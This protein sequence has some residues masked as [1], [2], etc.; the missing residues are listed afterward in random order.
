M[1][2]LAVGVV[3]DDVEEGHRPQPVVQ[4]G[5]LLVDGEV[6]LTVIG[7]DEPLHRPFAQ[8]SVAQHGRRD[9]TE[10]ERF[11]QQVGG[12]LPAVQ[13][14]LEVP[15]RT[16]SAHRLVDRRVRQTFVFDVDEERGVAAVRHPPLDAD[17]AAEQVS[18][19]IVDVVDAQFDVA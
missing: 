2:A 6:V 11:A 4:L 7:G 5:E 9:H 12:D 17:L 16:L 15:Q 8:R 10:A 19:R 13:T 18:D 14:G 3:G 1:A